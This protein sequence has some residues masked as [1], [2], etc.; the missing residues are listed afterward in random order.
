[1]EPS[2]DLIFAELNGGLDCRSYLIGSRSAREAILVDPLE[3]RVPA[4]LEALRAHGL[5]L[6]FALDTHTHADHLSASR[7]LAEQLHGRTA[8]SPAGSVDLPLGEGDV[9]TLGAL[10]LEVWA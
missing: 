4:Y 3:E 1:M 9:L 6:A 5:N 2:P 8:G 7:T 10:R